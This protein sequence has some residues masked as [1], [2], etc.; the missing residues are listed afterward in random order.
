MA[1]VGADTLFHHP[2]GTFCR[3]CD[4]VDKKNSVLKKFKPSE[5]L[6]FCVDEVR[7]DLLGTSCGWGETLKEK[8]LI[9]NAH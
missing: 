5:S 4:D 7:S 6:F 1:D 9:C 8:D 3:M 2:L